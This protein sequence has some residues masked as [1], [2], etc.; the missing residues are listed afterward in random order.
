MSENSNSSITQAL[1][2]MFTIAVLYVMA[3]WSS[4]VSIAAIAL[5]VFSL[6]TIIND[7]FSFRATSSI[8]TSGMFFCDLL[9]LFIVVNIISP[10]KQITQLG[11]SP[12]YWIYFSILVFV[13]ALW[14]FFVAQVPKTNDE[15]RK[16]LYNWMRIMILNGFLSIIAYLIQ[17]LY[18][19]NELF[20]PYKDILA[21]WIPILP[22]GMFV[23]TLYVWNMQK[24]E[25]L[26]DQLFKSVNRRK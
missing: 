18:L 5:Y 1:D 8:Y 21:T 25:W 22:A 2:L 17:S 7:W 15:R 4:I 13:Y 11:Y 3:Q 12:N 19:K 10:L 23:G 14:D 26:R 16:S 9:I 6:I 20:I 24:L